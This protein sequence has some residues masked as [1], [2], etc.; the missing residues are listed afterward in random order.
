[1]KDHYI[2]PIKP[3]RGFCSTYIVVARGVPV[4]AILRGRC[5]TAIVIEVS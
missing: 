1:M 5:L 4:L 2:S 3:V